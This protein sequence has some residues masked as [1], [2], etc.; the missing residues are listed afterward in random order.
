MPIYDKDGTT[1][2]EIGKLY[3]NDGTA[4]H[5]IGKAYDH[6]GTASS[7]IYSA[8]TNLGSIG[9]FGTHWL[10]NVGAY[11][12][13]ATKTSDTYLDVSGCSSLTIDWMTSMYNGYSHGNGNSATATI[14]AKF[15]D[16]A[17]IELGSKYETLYYGGSTA[18][19]NGT[20]TVDCTGK[21]KL[22]LYVTLSTPTGGGGTSSDTNHMYLDAAFTQVIGG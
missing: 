6:D 7:L 11:K 19:N 17:T 5:Q 13:T 18:E 3:D 16:G 21:T 20:T 12:A 1:S 10:L 15:E 4:N 22:Y 2:L 9:P 14:Y 8:E